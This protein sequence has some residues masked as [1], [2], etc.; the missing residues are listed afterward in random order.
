[1][2]TEINKILTELTSSAPAGELEEVFNDLVTILPDQQATIRKSVARL[3]ETQGIV[4]PGEGIAAQENKDESS[5]KF[6]DFKKKQKY[7][8]SFV[9]SKLLDR[10]AAAPDVTYPSMYN[11]LV[12]NLKQYGDSQ[13]PSQFE[14]NVIPHSST[15]L[16]VLLIG[17]K[18]NKSNFYTGRWKSVYT[19][20]KHEQAH[21]DITIDIH[22]YEEGNVRFKFDE[23]VQKE[24]EFSPSAIVGFIKSVENAALM[25]VIS[26][27]TA[28]N[29]NH[30]KNLRRLLPVT[31]SRINWGNAIGNYKL[32]TDVINEQ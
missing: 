32:G 15:K 21:G 20:D 19:F 17:Q 5:G 27:F 6:W 25:K 22:Y 13:F 10:E 30:F 26:Q 8:A 1:M 29:Q 4:V 24:C 14:F 3:A 12:E 18:L 16:T 23:S 2:S 31:K 7:N 11:E 28:L 9:D